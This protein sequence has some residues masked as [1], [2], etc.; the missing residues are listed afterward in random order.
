[1]NVSKEKAIDG[2]LTY[3]V[4]IK[5]LKSFSKSSIS[6]IEMLQFISNNSQLDTFIKPRKIL[7]STNIHHIQESV[8]GPYIKG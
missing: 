2:T 6:P 1:M 4:K 7:N 3:S 5:I 8:L